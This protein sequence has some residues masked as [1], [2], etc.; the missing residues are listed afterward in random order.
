[1]KLTNLVL[2]ILLRCRN[3]TEFCVYILI[4]LA[5][6]IQNFRI[7]YSLPDWLRLYFIL[8]FH[9]KIL[10]LSVWKISIVWCWLVIVTDARPLI[11]LLICRLL[12]KLLLISKIRF[13][14]SFSINNLSLS[15]FYVYLF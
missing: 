12:I 7:K 4:Y 5:Q 15:I 10:S 9:L 1:M 2:H 6:L 8:I 11:K 3:R 13:F 14:I